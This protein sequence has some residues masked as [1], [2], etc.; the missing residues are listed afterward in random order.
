MATRR[1]SA[2]GCQASPVVSTFDVDFVRV[3]VEANVDGVGSVDVIGRREQD[4]CGSLGLR[5]MSRKYKM[6][7]RGDLRGGI[8][9]ARLAC[10]L[11]VG[12]WGSGEDV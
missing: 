5:V 7:D 2:N 10:M 11:D 8:L 1:A 4:K 3:E 9:T 6:S 12:E